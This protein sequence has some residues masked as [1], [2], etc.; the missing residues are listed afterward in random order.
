[1]SFEERLASAVRD[2][3]QR[4]YGVELNGI[5]VERPNDPSHGDFA[6]NVALVNAKVLRRNPREVAENLVGALNAPF[7]R[8]AEVAGPG[9]VNFR[10]SPEAL[11]DEMAALLD[12]G[13]RY[14]RGEP[15]GD[16]V[17]LEF[18][19]ANPT[20]PLLVSHGRHAA[21]GDSLGRIMEAAGA[22]VSRECYLNDG[23]NQ[24]RLLGQSVAA[25]YAELYNRE[26]PVSSPEVLYRGEYVREIARDLKGEHGDIYLEM[27]QKEALPEIGAFAIRWCIEDI[28]QTLE[29]SRVR[30]DTFF[31]ETSLY[32]S[33]AVEEV[34]RD[35]VES[36]N[37]YEG[38]GALWLTTSKFGD[39]KD[40]VLV[41]SDGSYTYMVPDLA[42]HRDKWYRGFRQAVDVL[43]A[44]HA[45]YP[46]R[47]RAGLVS[48][49]VPRDFLHVEIIRLVKL[50]RGGEQVKVSRRAGNI[51]TFDELLDEVGE[52]VARYFYVRSSHKTEMNFDLDLAIKHSEENPVFYVQYAHARISSIFQRAGTSPETLGE[53]PAGDLEHEE[54]L[55]VLELLDFPRVIQNAAAR[56]EVH[57]VPTYLETL[58]TRFHQ[59]Y[60]VHRVLVEGA[61]VRARRLALCAATK[62]VL[63][64]GLGLLGVNAPEKM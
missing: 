11:W 41:K 20:G 47:I 3:V 26:W 19:S 44:D 25:S 32:E 54:R 29:R 60:T 8:V 62:T 40:R 6:T 10:L 28:E 16:P 48:L 5:H 61:E 17:L 58:A 15:S 35:L 21:Y 43:G 50:I 55:L 1:M 18:V 51:V 31:K 24:I 14:G 59:F 13:E 42:Y 4:T 53:F 45:G 33:G 56:R 34:V 52:D 37:A 22:I 64:S 46:P 23:G 38:D 57:P 7:V 49:G 27:P 63:R 30:F 39:D 9:F 12:A 2:A 36:G